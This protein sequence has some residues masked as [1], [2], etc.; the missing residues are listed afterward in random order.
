MVY[1][2]GN[3]PPEFDVLP[4]DEDPTQQFSDTKLRVIALA[5]A[6]EATNTYETPDFLVADKLIAVADKLHEWLRKDQ[7]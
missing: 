4:P 3:P 6:I 7:S 2:P 5:A 1:G